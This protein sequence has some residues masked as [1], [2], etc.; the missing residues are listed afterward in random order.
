MYNKK[1]T[2]ENILSIV[3][4]NLIP[5]EVLVE[6]TKTKV[7]NNKDET[8][9]NSVLNQETLEEKKRIDTESIKSNSNLNWE[10]QSLV[11]GDNNLVEYKC[12]ISVPNCFF[13][14]WWFRVGTG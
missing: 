9:N 12:M 10:N 2:N 8:L 6:Q 4:P 14:I 1:P 5:N 11:S 13:S 7:S 3:E